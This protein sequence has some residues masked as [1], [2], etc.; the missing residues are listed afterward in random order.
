MGFLGPYILEAGQDPAASVETDF[1]QNVQNVSGWGLSRPRA[2]VCAD[3]SEFLAGVLLRACQ[4]RRNRSSHQSQ[5]VP[6]RMERGVSISPS[7]LASLEPK[8]SSSLRVL[9][10]ELG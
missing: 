6:R 1:F 3:A 4:K 8:I 7:R 2:R 10:L 5:G 9:G